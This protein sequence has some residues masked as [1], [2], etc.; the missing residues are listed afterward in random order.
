M[1]QVRD[2]LARKGSDVLTIEPHCSVLEATQLMNRRQVGALVVTQNQ[3]ILGI[4]TERDVLRRIVAQEIS[5]SETR[6]ADVMTTNLACATL[7]TELDEAS[8]VM[9]NRRIRHLPVCDEAGHLQGLISIGD[10]NA[11][12]ANDKE[13]TIHFLNQYIHGRT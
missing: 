6:I 10:L 7:D 1:P 11:W 5:P 4:F 8:S 13:T 3:Q 12:Y 2:L 9:K